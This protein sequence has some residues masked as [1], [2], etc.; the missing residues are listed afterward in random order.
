M[1][2]YVKIFQL[3]SRCFL[4]HLRIHI[5]L[6]SWYY[7]KDSVTKISTT[8]CILAIRFKKT[9][10]C[11]AVSIKNPKLSAMLVDSG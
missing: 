9:A 6:Q 2:A 11:L 1:V 10:C 8:C 5:M 4:A 3:I 7:Y